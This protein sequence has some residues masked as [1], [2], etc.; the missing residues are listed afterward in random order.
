LRY[1]TI[2]QT[3]TRTRQPDPR[4]TRAI[5][6]ALALG[7]GERVADIGAGTGNYAGELATQGLRVVA[8]EPSSVMRAQR[9]TPHT[10]DWI[11]AVAEHL[12]LADRS[13]GGALCMLSSHH[14][15]AFAKAMSELAR[16]VRD[17]PIVLL[18]FDPRLSTPFWLEDYF[19]SV[20][21]ESFRVFPPIEDIAEMLATQTGRSTMLK[22]LLLPW[23][24][25]DFVAAAG[26]RTPEIYL[27]PVVRAGMSPFALGDQAAI[28]RGV[29]TLK[30]DLDSGAWQRA[31]AALLNQDALDVGYRFVIATK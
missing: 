12:P 30:H 17:G 28:E 26:W 3:Y 24:L 15:V 21:R 25:R 20:W 8:V 2:G 31:N 23:D 14:F 1:D 5:V 22:P 13:V 19:P 16:I 18:T 10:V 4:L 29:A 7:P 6:D 27:D 11:A 9:T